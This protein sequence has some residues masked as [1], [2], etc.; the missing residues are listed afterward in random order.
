MLRMTRF[1]LIALIVFP[2]S[3]ASAQRPS[4][5]VLVA[6][7]DSIVR[8]GLASNIAGIQVAVVK[9]R[10]T[11]LMKGYGHANLELGVPLNADHVLRIG[12]LAKQF[13]A[14]AI[15][16]LVEQG[17]VSL[18]DP[19]TKY[20]ANIPPG[21]SGVKVRHL[22]S[23]TSGTQSFTELPIRRQVDLMAV[24]RDSMVQLMARA[25]MMFEPG[26][27]FYY[28]NGGYFLLGMVLERASGHAYA[29][30]VAQMVA[31]IG[32]TQT[33]HCDVAPLIAGRAAGYNRKAEGGYT[34]APYLDMNT[35]FA[36]GDL[37]STARDLVKWSN[38]LASGR[39]VKPATYQLMTTPVRYGSIRQGS[40]GMGLMADSVDG[41]LVISHTGSVHGFSAMLLHL[42]A[43]SLTVAVL[44]NTLEAP[45]PE[46]GRSIV[47]AVLGLREPRIVVLDQPVSDAER[48]ALVGRY[49]VAL[50]DGTRG[51]M[52]IA[53]E[54]GRLILTMPRARQSMPLH[55]QSAEVF[56]VPGQ[57]GLK[58][59]VDIRDGVVREVIVDRAN[60]PAVGRPIR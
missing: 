49:Q 18:D 33:R 55:R 53:D 26:T 22:L 58:I 40:Y 56:A 46:I 3:T 1:L 17:K 60:R 36:G 50:P 10:D 41:H 21:W 45:S 19:L 24:P 25:P 34:N 59:W 43:D 9:G 28:N 52:T 14:A 13:T 16:Q 30:H 31:P 6:R 48:R 12:S 11:L 35:P 42:P 29:D 27:G 5:G 7:I 57:V 32:L 44:A 23:H 8:A 2:C 47:R 4:R 38:A 39:V 20:I 15:M 51:E 37:C 54:N